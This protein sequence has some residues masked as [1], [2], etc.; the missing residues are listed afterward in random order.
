MII[1]VSLQHIQDIEMKKLNIKPQPLEL[2]RKRKKKN[3]NP[4]SVKKKK[5]IK[6]C[7]KK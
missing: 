7:T 5:L 1:E 2:S 3:P 6:D 4:L